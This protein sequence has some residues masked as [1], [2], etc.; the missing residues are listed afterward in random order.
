MFLFEQ[1]IHHLPRHDEESL[2]PSDNNFHNTLHAGWLQ[3]SFVLEEDLISC[4]SPNYAHDFLCGE[5]SLK[6]YH[7]LAYLKSYH[8]RVNVF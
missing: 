5:K 8:C 3:Q 6:H 4:I 7:I 1:V 2:A